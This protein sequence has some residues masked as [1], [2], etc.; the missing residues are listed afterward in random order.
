MPH[1]ACKAHSGG[2][3]RVVFWELEFCGENTALE[4]GAFGALDQSFP[5]EHVLL[6]DWASGDSLR[7]VPSEVLI[8]MF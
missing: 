4:W 3:K 6:G 1:V 2:R 5:S 8:L 7:R